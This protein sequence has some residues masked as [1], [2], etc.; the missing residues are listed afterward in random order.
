MPQI[1]ELF[2]WDGDHESVRRT[3]DHRSSPLAE[4]GLNY[5][6]ANTDSL[7]K[8]AGAGLER[9]RFGVATRPGAGSN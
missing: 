8:V 6:L 7:F 1:V 2:L 5:R 9:C 3:F 4:I